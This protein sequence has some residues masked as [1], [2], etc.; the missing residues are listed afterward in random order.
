M[1]KEQPPPKAGAGAN[2]LASTSGWGPSAPGFLV[3]DAVVGG[4]QPTVP[5]PALAQ[6]A[7]VESGV[8]SEKAQ[9]RKRRSRSRRE[10]TGASLPADA[11]AGSGPLPR[12]GP[13]DP[14]AGPPVGETVREPN[15][16]SSPPMAAPASEV[17]TEVE[18]APQPDPSPAPEAAPVMTAPL[19]ALPV[20]SPGAQRIEAP[21]P[22]VPAMVTAPARD[23]SVVSA[24]RPSGPLPTSPPLPRAV[25]R[26][27]VRS[28]TETALA[29][30]VEVRQRI[31]PEFP[32]GG[33]IALVPGIVIVLLLIGP[34]LVGIA[35]LGW[36][37]A[38]WNRL[39]AQGNSF[40]FSTPAPRYPYQGGAFPGR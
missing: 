8:N 39:P 37:L 1:D 22:L 5:K 34:L 29:S 25:E 26:P 36:S 4:N 17:A 13:S 2:P 14:P 38:G 10:T 32:P 31:R 6:T 7:E 19:P 35:T 15:A 28:P 24:P 11:T 18:G 30:I 23:A 3:V 27:K 40:G 16:A 21:P 20:E 33:A 12:I 9:S